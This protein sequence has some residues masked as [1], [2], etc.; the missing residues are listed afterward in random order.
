M[1]GAVRSGAAALPPADGH[2]RIA[3]SGD[4]DGDGHADVVVQQE[5]AAV[6]HIWLMDGPNR[7]GDA[8]LP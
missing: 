1:G 2:W 6:Y 3:A 8:A 7:I 5:D 4:F